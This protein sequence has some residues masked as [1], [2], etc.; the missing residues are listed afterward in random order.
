VFGP[1]TVKLPELAGYH[2][3]PVIAG[4]QW[5]K[6]TNEL[7]RAMT[8]ERTI[9]VIATD[10]NSSH[11]AEQLGNRLFV[12]VLAVSSDRALTSMGVPW[13]FRVPT[14]DD[15]VAKLA[16]VATEAGPNR[17]RIRD[18]LARNGIVAV[19]NDQ[20]NPESR[21]NLVNHR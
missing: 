13:I 15:A 1:D 8:D 20:R 21:D 14:I 16:A 10:R 3:V 5:G 9:A 17:G 4:Q 12:P 6:S 19:I 7:V 11:L 2:V 18:A